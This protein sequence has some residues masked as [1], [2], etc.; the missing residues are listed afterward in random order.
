MGCSTS[1]SNTTT[2][3]DQHQQTTGALPDNRARPI[4]EIAMKVR[5]M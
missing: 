3:D 2:D 4:T 1:S 5:I